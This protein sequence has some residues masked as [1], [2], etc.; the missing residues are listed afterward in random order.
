MAI[1][2]VCPST[3]VDAPVER[4]WEIVTQPQGFDLWADASLVTAEPP[5]PASAGQELHLVTRAL[6]WTFA[7][8]ISVREVDAERHRL[9]LV[10]ALPFGVVNDEVMTFAEAGEGRTLVRFG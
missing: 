10:V 4:V 2:S 5:G 3:V 7:V 6:G 1:V 9:H 8:R